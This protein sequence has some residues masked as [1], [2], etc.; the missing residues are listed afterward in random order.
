MM[1]MTAAASVVFVA[2][3]MLLNMCNNLTYGY[4]INTSSHGRHLSS[5]A[6]SSLS[7]TS[8]SLSS[9]TTDPDEITTSFEESRRNALGRMALSSAGIIGTVMSAN[10][11][12]KAETTISVGTKLTNL[13]D[14]ELADKIRGDVVKKQ[15]LVT[16]NL[17]RELYDESATFTDEIDTYALEKWMK[18]TQRLFVASKSHVD[19]EPNSLTVDK[20]QAVFRFSE[21]LCFNIPFLQPVVFLS[22][23]VVLKRDEST[24]LIT[25]YQEFWDQ[26]VA[27]VLKT[28]K[29]FG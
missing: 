18:G 25:S 3:T 20:T 15:F 13:S 28:A 5:Q 6:D 4:V 16:G 21:F 29:F 24:G 27:S 10:Q 26:D 1:M 11:P 12:V 23:K 14:D 9:S 7:T 8:S 22:G 19:L 2:A 17:S